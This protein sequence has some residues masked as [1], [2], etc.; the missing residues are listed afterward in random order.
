M[1]AFI[2]S[3]PFVPFGEVECAGCASRSHGSALR[4]RFD[5]RPLLHLYDSVAGTHMVASCV[6]ACTVISCVP[7]LNPLKVPENFF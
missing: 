6:A 5:H 3:V 2:G 1:V 7:L 4:H